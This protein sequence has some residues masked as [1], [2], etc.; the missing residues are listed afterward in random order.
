[1][2]EEAGRALWERMEAHHKAGY[3]SLH[4]PGHKENAALAPYLARLGAE[5]DITELPEFDDL[6]DP[7]G[8]LAQGMDRAAKLWESRKSYF[9]VNG[10]TGGLLAAIRAAKIRNLSLDLMYGL[11][12]QSLTAWEETLEHVLELVARHCHKA[13][14][15]AIELCGLDPVFLL[16]P[17]EETFGLAGSLS[18]E[19][20][21]QALEDHP[22]VKLVVY[23]S[24]TYDGVVSDTAGICAAAH[25]KG[26]PVLVDEAHGAHLGFHPAFPPGAMAQGADLAVASLHKMLPSLTQTALL[27]AGGKL[28]PLPQVARQTGIFQSSSPSYLLMASMDGCVRLLEE[29]GEALFAAWHRRLTE[30]D[31]G[32]QGLRHLRVLGHGREA[33]AH[34]PGIFALD[35]AKI[36]IS[37]Q[38]TGLTGV[39][40][41]DLLRREYRIEVEMALDHYVLAMTGLG[42]DDAMPARLAQALLAIDETCASSEETP[43][44][45][46]VPGALPPRRCSLEEAAQAPGGLSFLYDAMGKV[47]GEYIWAYPPGIP[48]IAPG[49][50]ITPP[51]VET[52]EGLYRAGVRLIGTRGKPPFTTFALGDQ[53]G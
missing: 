16:P 43:S 12:G 25:A 29:K 23:P 53:D 28:V 45:L 21:A 14:Y 18:P 31:Q 10:S 34:Y 36:L 9:Q 24:P 3:L 22:G 20:V 40:L 7:S 52:V 33:G 47:C 51:L 17:V 27:H 35:P 11:P 1:M 50:E 5:L 49:E 15:H 2:A 8:V 13:V 44:V 4:M 42:T 19:Q 38:G 37:T 48:L 6:H 32:I 39:A 30:F 41:R 46:T 26:V